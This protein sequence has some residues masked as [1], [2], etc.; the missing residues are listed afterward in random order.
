MSQVSKSHNSF[1]VWS[2][3][4]QGVYLRAFSIVIYGQFN[5]DFPEF[6]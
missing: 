3:L 4:R 1:M 2:E 5:F 6:F